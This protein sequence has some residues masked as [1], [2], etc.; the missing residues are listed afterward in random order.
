MNHPILG[1]LEKKTPPPPPPPPPPP[2]KKKTRR[3]AA[4]AL[5]L[6]LSLPA[7]QPFYERYRYND[8][9]TGAGRG[10][11]Q[12]GPRRAGPGG[13][14]PGIPRGQPLRRGK[15]KARHTPDGMRQAVE[16]QGIVIGVGDHDGLARVGFSFRTRAT[17]PREG[18]PLPGQP[19][20]H[21]STG[22][23]PEHGLQPPS[24]AQAAAM[25]YPRSNQERV[26]EAVKAALVE[27]APAAFH[28][29]YLE[30]S[31]SD[32]VKE[33]LATRRTG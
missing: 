14:P 21:P 11:R 5:G 23:E 30:D 17:P 31:L 4:D 6:T 9:G 10:G 32:E 29:E 25:E 20:R 33:K 7:F 3:K 26:A 15:G 8:G 28:R 27:Q 24:D 1:E 19:P 12:G 18:G 13:I 22:L 2:Q 16:L